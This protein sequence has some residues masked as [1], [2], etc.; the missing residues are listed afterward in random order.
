MELTDY[1]VAF[2]LSLHCSRCAAMAAVL[3]S[4]NL[5]VAQYALLKLAEHHVGADN[6]TRLTRRI[7]SALEL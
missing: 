1:D 5:G 4:T 3:D 6:Y 2:K 7:A